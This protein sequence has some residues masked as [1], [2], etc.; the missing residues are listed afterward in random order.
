MRVYT[1]AERLDGLQALLGG[2]TGKVICR[3]STSGR[4]WRL[5]ETSWPGAVMDVRE[6]IDQFL[7]QAQRKVPW[8]GPVGW[9]EH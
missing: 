1:D 7:A 9:E 8:Q 6:A 5:A 3:W 2:Y 4:G